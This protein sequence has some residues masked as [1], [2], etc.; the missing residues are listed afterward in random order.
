MNK[1]KKDNPYSFPVSFI[2][3]IYTRDYVFHLPYRQKTEGIIKATRKN[4]L[5]IQVM[6][7]FVKESTKD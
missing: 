3:V 7:I 1:N 4:L 2:L 5:L 6:V